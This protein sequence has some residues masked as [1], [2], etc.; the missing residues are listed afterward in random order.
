MFKDN[1]WNELA[2]FAKENYNAIIISTDIIQ[3]QKS[4]LMIKKENRIVLDI[5]DFKWPTIAQNLKINDIKQ[6]IKILEK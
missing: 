2:K 1:D 3:L 4:K 5:G 6:L